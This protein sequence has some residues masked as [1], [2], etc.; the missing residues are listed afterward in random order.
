M[1]EQPRDRDGK[2]GPK[3]HAEDDDISL[4]A[5]AAY[6]SDETVRVRR[7]VDVFLGFAD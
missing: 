4:A 2:F 7:A 5:K 3:P 6:A 1:T